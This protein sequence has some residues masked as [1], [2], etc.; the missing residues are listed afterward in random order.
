MRIIVSLRFGAGD[1]TGQAFSFLQPQSPDINL[2]NEIGAHTDI[3]RHDAKRDA[4]LLCDD[5]WPKD[6]EIWICM[7]AAAS[8]LPLEK[9]TGHFR[10]IDLCAS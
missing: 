9:P 8:P 2:E 10:P 5:A 4:A 7:K 3:N 6:Q 1:N